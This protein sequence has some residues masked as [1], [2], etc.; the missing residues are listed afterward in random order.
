MA[1][2]PV[3]TVSDLEAEPRLD[4]DR[5]VN[6]DAV[7]LGLIAVALIRE[8]ELSL[9]VHIRLRGDVVFVAKLGAT[10]PDNDRWI[11]G[12]A[13]VVT[14]FGE[15]SLLVRRRRESE[16]NMAEWDGDDRSALFAGG[17]L[18]IRVGGELVGT[19]TLSGEPDVID[20]DVAAEAV[21]RYLAR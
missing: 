4:L 14:R 18:P 21:R 12:K 17:S 6:D 9:A 3:F 13:A 5:F 1:D 10:G 16:G 15:A 7:D 11:A 8:R 20:H 2:L 19:F